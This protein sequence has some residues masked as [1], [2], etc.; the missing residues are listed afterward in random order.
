MKRQFDTKFLRIQ[1]N[2]SVCMG[3]KYVTQPPDCIQTHC[4]ELQLMFS[5]SLLR[6]AFVL[7]FINSGT[8]FFSG[9]VVFS[10]LGF[11]ASEQGVDISKV[12]ESGKSLPSFT[13]IRVTDYVLYWKVRQTNVY[14]RSI[15]MCV[16][17]SPDL[18]TRPEATCI[19][20][21]VFNNSLW[22][23]FSAHT[24]MH[25]WPGAG[26]CKS[27][28]RYIIFNARMICWKW[29]KHALCESWTYVIWWW[30]SI[31]NEFQCSVI[32]GLYCVLL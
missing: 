9:F 27:L 23:V 29:M 24:W 30:Y 28:M 5:S 3:S 11:M 25:F 2:V 26:S 14:F 8:S 18:S 15:F 10:I 22:L 20:M 19:L 13:S 6:D 7:A 32:C 16:S 17:S 1:L 31:V 12:A 21:Q 4:T